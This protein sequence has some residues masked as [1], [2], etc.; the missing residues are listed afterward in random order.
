MASGLPVVASNAGSIPEVVDEAGFLF[1]PNDAKGMTKAINLIMDDKK[2]REEMI[3]KGI[4]QSSLFTWEKSIE[5]TVNVYKSLINRNNK[6][7]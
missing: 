4:K 6:I 7:K 2:I 1:N 5:K 3:D